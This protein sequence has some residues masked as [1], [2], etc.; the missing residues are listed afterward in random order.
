ML[1][2]GIYI[3][4]YYNLSKLSVK[5]IKVITL[6]RS[7]IIS[8]LKYFTIAKLTAAFISLGLI[9]LLRYTIAGGFYTNPLNIQEALKIGI[10]AIII[11]IG[12]QG[13]VDYIFEDLGLRIFI[14]SL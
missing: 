14:K 2:V 9:I 11:R 13:M 7:I 3:Y 5:L 4:T 10:P 6:T 12:I 8:I 1:L